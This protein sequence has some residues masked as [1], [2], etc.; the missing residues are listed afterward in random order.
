MSKVAGW[1]RKLK[2]ITI[3]EKCKILKEIEKGESS[4]SISK[5]YGVPKQTLSG[6]LKEKTKIYSEVKKSKTSKK[7]V[8]MQLSTHDDLNKACYMWL[9]NAQHQSIPVSGTIFKVKALYF[10]EDLWCDSFQASD[11]WLD[12]WKKIYN[13]SFKTISG[14]F[15]FD[16]ILIFTYFWKVAYFKYLSNHFVHEII[17]SMELSFPFH[18]LN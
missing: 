3:T 16:H 15:S 1:K 5:K 11:R 9:W 14:I 4:A 10:A 8:R 12:R 2:T 7:R 13:V 18:L 6:W 17:I